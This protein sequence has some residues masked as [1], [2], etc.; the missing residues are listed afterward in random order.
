MEQLEQML[1]RA[2]QH[3]RIRRSLPPPRRRQELRRNAGL[4]QADVGR[5]LGVSRVAVSRWES[6][7]RRPSAQYVG[8]YGELL[9]RLRA[10]GSDG[11]P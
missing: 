4:T 1:D 10:E 7:R 6:G 2:R 5:V 9:A 8:A 11:R 3:R